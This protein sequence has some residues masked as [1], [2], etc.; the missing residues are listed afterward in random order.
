MF[1]LL[2]IL[3]FL[4]KSLENFFELLDVEIGFVLLAGVV[5]DL[6]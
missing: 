5:A 6:R 2:C 1:D 4:W 3:L